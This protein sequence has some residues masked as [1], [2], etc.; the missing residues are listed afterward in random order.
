MVWL[1]KGRVRCVFAAL[2]F[3][4]VALCLP[5]CR[6]TATSGDSGRLVYV[7]TY[8]DSS[9]GI[10]AYRFDAFTGKLTALGLAADSPNASFLAVALDGH[11]LY[12][13][14]ELSSFNGQPTGSVSAF[15]VDPATGKLSPLN[16]GSSRAAGPAYIT[17]DRTGRYALVANYSIG[18]VAVF[19]ILPNGMLGEASAFVQHIGSSVNPQRQEGP[20]AHAIAMSPDN[21]FAIVADLGLDQLIIYPFDPGKGRL[22]PSRTIRTAPG[23]GPRHLIFSPNGR[24]L[25]VINEMSSTVAVYAYGAEN[26]G[27]RQLQTISTLPKG[28]TGTN[29]AAEIDITSSGRFLYASNRGNDSIAV[30]AIG[31]AKGALTLVEVSPT[32]G[33]TPRNFAIDPTESWLL[34]GN[35]DSDDIVVFRIDVN[36]GH[37]TAT[38]ETVQ[39]S[40]PVCIKFLPQP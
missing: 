9:K 10:Y 8:T 26:G 15:A 27:L 3:V 11:R 39:L 17:L 5:R 37:L 20:H 35:Q 24:F 23:A 33:R 25:Y 38:G 13:V 32:G 31:P 14:N 21:R 2:F 12:A 1:N 28:F 4:A 29:T 7:G 34:A 18:S 30:F 22:G 6:A 16:R 19:P 40:K 36:T